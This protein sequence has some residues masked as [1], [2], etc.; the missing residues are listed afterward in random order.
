MFED[1][2]M[3]KNRGQSKVPGSISASPGDLGW[4]FNVTHCSPS[5]MVLTCRQQPQP[6]GSAT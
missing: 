5:Q 1:I 2:F 3:K 6:D 4:H